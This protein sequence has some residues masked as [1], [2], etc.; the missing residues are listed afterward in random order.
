MKKI[1]L[2]V[3]LTVSVLCLSAQNHRHFLPV[4]TEST[5]ILREDN[6]M[7]E[8]KTVT[9]TDGSRFN[10]VNIINRKILYTIPKHLQKL[11]RDEIDMIMRQNKTIEKITWSWFIVWNTIYSKESVSNYFSFFAIK[12]ALFSF[13]GMFL[14]V[15]LVVVGR[16]LRHN[17]MSISDALYVLEEKYLWIAIA[18]GSGVISFALTMFFYD[19][20]DV[21]FPL[22][23]V[24]YSLIIGFIS[25]LLTLWY[26][27]YHPQKETD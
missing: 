8:E 25:H 20:S 26:R 4:T 2:T 19:V 22:I 18:L 3:Y 23:Y 5:V 14:V 17:K 6:I 21:I 24:P 7:Y 13:I 12:A 10:T 27:K 16:F 9:T 15:Y 1:I 11:D